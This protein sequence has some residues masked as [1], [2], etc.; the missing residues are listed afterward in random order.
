M[1]AKEIAHMLARDAEGVASYLLPKGNRDGHEWVC[2]N[3]HGDEGKS[4][5]VHLTGTK[6]GVWKDFAD[7]HGGDLLDLWCASRGIGLR[8]AIAE[9][10][11][12]LGIRDTQVEREEKLA[13]VRY[14]TEKPSG[15]VLEYLK[16]RGLSKSIDAYRVTQ[17]RNA[18]CFP[19]YV[20]DAVVFAKLRDVSDKSKM[21]CVD[22]GKP[23]LFGWQAI[24]PESRAVVICE[25]E[26]DA[27]AWYEMG[28]PA[29][30]VPNGAKGH[31]WIEREYGRL[32]RFDQIFLAFDADDEGREGV[33]VLL[34]RLGKE[35]CRVVDT[36]PYKDG[37]DLLLAGEPGREYVNRAKW[38][39]P[40]ELRNANEYTSEI[41]KG[42][43]DGF[44]CGP[45]FDSPW[46]KLKGN[47]RFRQS[48]LTVINGINGHG[49]SQLVGQIVLSAM[50]QGWRVCK[51]SLEMRPQ[52]LLAR[53]AR[54]ATAGNVT[55]PKITA[56]GNWYQD[57]FWL[58]DLVGTA[59]ADRLL[60]VMKYA[61]Q[62]YDCRLFVI[63]SLMKCGLAED[64]YN[65]QKRFIE[66]L[67]DFKNQHECHVILV[68]HSRKG[69]SEEKPIN[70]MDVKGTGS[71]TDLAD[72]VI[73]VW[74][75]KRKE[76]K[77]AELNGE[78]PPKELLEEFDALMMVDKQ[79]NGEWE[80]RAKLWFD[81]SSHQFR[82]GYIEEVPQY[83]GVRAVQ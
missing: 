51:A 45:G 12:Y 36:A 63:D 18:V 52:I 11:E 70:K 7:D 59:K 42:L 9:A 6:A 23:V 64:D 15:G 2:G 34:D 37:N 62:R 53:M 13:A 29:L 21:R 16:N 80:G 22:G 72:T 1:R 14:P 66:A 48:E 28:C 68:T 49:K 39:D 77:L 46:R 81:R 58:F 54:Q 32:E 71:I 17:E 76:R 56:L 30:S 40:E 73:S 55:D 19:S 31:A 75:N 61:R 5:K 8:E 25:G 67:C 26:L 10:K 43:R 44:D 33:K 60:D 78:P 35:R 41:I 50:Q 65:A 4:L 20:D 74:R 3:V 83:G 38:Q 24:R 69:D 82:G 47:V 57:K 79:R 27:M